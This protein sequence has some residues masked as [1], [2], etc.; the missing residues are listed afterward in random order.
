MKLSL[1]SAKTE[2]GIVTFLKPLQFKNALGPIDSSVVGKTSEVI[3]EQLAKASSPSETRP[4][5]ND[6]S[7]I[8]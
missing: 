7:V 3:L 2:F 5:P 6:I 4:S 8:L 1:K